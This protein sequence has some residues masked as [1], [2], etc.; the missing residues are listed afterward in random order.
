METFI[1]EDWNSGTKIISLPSS[2]RY[3][4]L[5]DANDVYLNDNY[6]F[7]IDNSCR[8]QLAY[9]NFENAAF[10]LKL[11]AFDKNEID[12]GEALFGQP[13]GAPQYQ[14][15]LGIGKRHEVAKNVENAE[16]FD[17]I[18]DFGNIYITKDFDGFD[19][20]IA[21]TNLDVYN[22]TETSSKLTGISTDVTYPQGGGQV[23]SAPIEIPMFWEDSGG[24]QGYVTATGTF[25]TYMQ[26]GKV[27]VTLRLRDIWVVGN[28]Y[29]DSST[30]RW[31]KGK[32]VKICEISDVIGSYGLK[33]QLPIFTF[34]K[35][36]YLPM[37]VEHWPSGVTFNIES[38]EFLPIVLMTPGPVTF[39]G[40]NIEEA[41]VYVIRQTDASADNFNAPDF[42]NFNSPRDFDYHLEF[43]AN[44]LQ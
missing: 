18:N 1:I 15:R 8:V 26:A 11:F 14:N 27:N 7:V 22:Q 21:R 28:K 32:Y 37:T 40:I 19:Y 29:Y 23:I 16:M 41:G 42:Y 39:A 44:D 38:L 33:P 34:A 36:A 20:D 10:P 13:L 43:F 4:D 12:S 3:V 31:I 30:Q 6:V 5:Y 2:V 24:S 35:V 25:A 17:F 9:E